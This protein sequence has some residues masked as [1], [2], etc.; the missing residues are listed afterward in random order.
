MKEF[1]FNHEHRA[2]ILKSLILLIQSLD[3]SNSDAF[4]NLCHPILF[5][6]QPVL[7]RLTS[8]Y[9]EL[10]PSELETLWNVMTEVLPEN[11]GLLKACYLQLVKETY[12]YAGIQL[13]E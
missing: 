1:L 4:Q 11:R 6:D 12:G 2:S 5:D 8:P 10:Q 7:Q 9:S 3:F 13:P